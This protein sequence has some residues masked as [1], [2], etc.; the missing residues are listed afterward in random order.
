LLGRRLLCNYNLMDKCSI[1]PSGGGLSVHVPFF[2]VNVVYKKENSLHTKFH[3]EIPERVPTS[4]PRFSSRRREEHSHV[5]VSFVLCNLCVSFV[6]SNHL[7]GYS[8]PRPLLGLHL[9]PPLHWHLL[10]CQQPPAVCE[11]RS[12][13]YPTWEAGPLRFEPLHDDDDAFYL[14]LQKQKIALRPYTLWVLSTIRRKNKH[15]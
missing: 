8:H 5:C 4:P 13:D 11:I 2:A 9:C 1:H 3:M 6:L 14:F 15:M 7:L 12:V 10:P